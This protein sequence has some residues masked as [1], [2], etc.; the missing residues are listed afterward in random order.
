[1]R[2][3][4]TASFLAFLLSPTVS[5]VA[6]KP[7]R[8][9]P[10][11]KVVDANWQAS[12]RDIHA[13]LHSASSQLWTHA[14][15]QKLDTIVVNRSNSGPIVLFR[16]GDKGQYFVNLDTN[17]QFWC[18]Y[19]FQFA[20]EFGHIICGYK[21]GSNDNQW[22][23]ESLC[24]TASLFAMRRMTEAWKT[25][26]PY[27][28]WK[29]YGPQFRKYAQDRIDEHP[30]PK[31]KSVAQW[32]RENAVALRKNPTDRQKNTTVAT[33]LLTLFEEK[34]E[35]WA[36]TAYLNVGKT[37]KSIDFRTYLA[38]WSTACPLKHKAFVTEIALLF[39]MKL[40]SGNR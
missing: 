6:A 28:N 8:T 39:G 11:I 21:A 38:D 2:V 19:A 37:N 36:A 12:L 31:Q 9:H 14:A 17:Q 35:R 29:S 25:A 7:T 15:Q 10:E 23:E 16:R 13:V 33:H 5:E 34:P 3:F 4:L 40:P 22:F 20:H 27:P 1:M 30:W 26:A 32:Y 18:Q 24:E